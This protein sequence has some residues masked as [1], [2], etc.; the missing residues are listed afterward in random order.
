MSTITID[1]N[2]DAKT[3]KAF[4]NLLTELVGDERPLILNP[5]AVSD[6]V[7]AAVEQTPTLGEAEPEAPH[8]TGG[9]STGAPA[10]TTSNEVDEK[11]VVFDAKF[12]GKAAIPFYGT[13]KRKGQWKKLRGVTDEAY[14]A[15]YTSQPKAE[16]TNTAEDD[17]PVNTAGAFSAD[18]TA[19][20]DSNAPTD[21]GSFMGWVSAKQAAELL[22]Q[23]DIGQA[24]LKV[25]V[26]VTDL[27]PPNDPATIEKHVTALYVMLS[28]KAGA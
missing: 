3:L 11:G 9:G 26:A 4:R 12:C 17:E 10:D 24:Y 27:F 16:V 14:D 13:G 23:D 21:C 1:T 18:T 7:T 25:G 6:A 20:P 22:T 5:N 19:A 2:D 8:T 15:W 28:V